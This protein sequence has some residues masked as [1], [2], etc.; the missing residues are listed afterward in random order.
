MQDEMGWDGLDAKQAGKEACKNKLD[1]VTADF[2]AVMS[3]LFCLAEHCPPRGGRHTTN[4]HYCSVQAWQNWAAPGW[5]GG[6]LPPESGGL[7]LPLPA[8]SRSPLPLTP[9]PSRH[10][11]FSCLPLSSAHKVACPTPISLSSTPPS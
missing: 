5:R 3:D 11:P 1:P 7:E 8:P 4:K 9:Y 6:C 2:A 10:L